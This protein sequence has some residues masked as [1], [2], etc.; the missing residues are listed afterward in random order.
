MC[1]CLELYRFWPHF[2]TKS[3]TL[4]FSISDNPDKFEHVPLN[5][6]GLDLMSDLSGPSGGGPEGGE[7]VVAAPYYRSTVPIFTGSMKWE[8]ATM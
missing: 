5:L 3:P 2:C 1:M 8:E 6:A 7:E 4:A